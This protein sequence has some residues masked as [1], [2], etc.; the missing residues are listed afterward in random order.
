MSGCETPACRQEGERPQELA[1][2]LQLLE[3][4]GLGE[5]DKH[6]AVSGRQL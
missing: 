4:G 3:S 6:A 5:C 2:N 1:D